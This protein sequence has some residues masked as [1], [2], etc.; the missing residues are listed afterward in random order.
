MNKPQRIDPPQRIILDI[1]ILHEHHRIGDTLRNVVHAAVHDGIKGH[2]APVLGIVHPGLGVVHVEHGVE[3]MAG[4]V[5]HQVKLTLAALEYR[6]VGDLAPLVIVG[7]ALHLLAHRAGQVV[8]GAPEVL[9]VVE[10]HLLAHGA[11]L[12]DMARAIGDGTNVDGQPLVAVDI[13]VVQAVD[14][15]LHEGVLGLPGVV[16]DKLLHHGGE[17]AN[18]RAGGLVPAAV[19]S[20][21]VGV[22]DLLMSL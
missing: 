10:P 4:V 6:V 17:A 3:V 20:A 18:N 2:E 16:D 21:V 22:G 9:V 8:H 14:L 15:M 13:A 12:H 1:Q 11:A 5:L 19:A 7:P